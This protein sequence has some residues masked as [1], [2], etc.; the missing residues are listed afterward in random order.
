M[1]L[2]G[3]LSSD[4]TNFDMVPGRCGIRPFKNFPVGLSGGGGG[5]GQAWN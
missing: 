4:H 1:P 2:Y 5:D 3:D